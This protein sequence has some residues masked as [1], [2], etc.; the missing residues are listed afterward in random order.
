MSAE[1]IAGDVGIL[2][3]LVRA[4]ERN[5]RPVTARALALDLGEPVAAVF[6][7]LA[8]LEEGGAAS[9]WIGK[10]EAPLFDRIAFSTGFPVEAL[11][12][13][14]ARRSS[15]SLAEA[16][17]RMFTPAELEAAALRRPAGPGGEIGER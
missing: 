8:A 4:V 10:G 13:E 14:A 12:A 1:R 17:G 15:V 2:L 9:V 11:A 6:G 7:A 5:R 3:A 16:L